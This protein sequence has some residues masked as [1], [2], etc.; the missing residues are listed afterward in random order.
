[1]KCMKHFSIVLIGISLFAAAPVL[2]A[3]V[4]VAQF[5]S[6][7]IVE[8]DELGTKTIIASGL[9]RPS[10]LNLDKQGNLFV[11]EFRK[12]F[13]L[14][15][16]LLKIT[17]AGDISIFAENFPRTR[18]DEFGGQI[19]LSYLDMTIADDGTIFLLVR[20]EDD[21]RST[22]IL[23]VVEG[24]T[25]NLLAAIDTPEAGGFRHT[26]GPGGHIYVATNGC[27][28][29]NSSDPHNQI[30]RVTRTGEVSTFFEFPDPP[31]GVDPVNGVNL[32]SVLFD[33]NG[34]MLLLA[35]K[36]VGSNFRAIYKLENE[37]LFLLT[38]VGNNPGSGGSGALSMTIDAADNLSLAGGGDQ[39]S[40]FAGCGDGFIQQVD[41]SGAVTTLA[42]F[43]T[44][45]LDPIR[46]ES[47]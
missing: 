26:I 5:G 34:D 8:V 42:L 38:D 12:Q 15:P 37:Q 22:E 7:N 31:I 20:V 3:S 46:G 4:F 40:S 17:P 28:T 6:G 47:K 29:C 2:A 1:M 36:A 14:N 23:E 25:P 27:V 33:S 13:A 35:H 21:P 44:E 16:R 39:C 9:D 32:M 11:F 24:G 45:A 19:S 41:P 30:L 43:L 18:A 10:Q